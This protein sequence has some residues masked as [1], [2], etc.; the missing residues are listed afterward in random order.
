MM[1]GMGPILWR[2]ANRVIHPNSPMASRDEPVPRNE[3]W[4]IADAGTDNP[5]YRYEY[6]AAHL[7]YQWL[8]SIN[9]REQESSAA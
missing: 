2:E 9:L 5:R 1:L 3:A 4:I 7:Y 8:D 6:P